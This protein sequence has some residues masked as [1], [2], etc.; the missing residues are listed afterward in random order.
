MEGDLPG[1]RGLSSAPESRRGFAGLP[2][3]GPTAYILIIIFAA[4]ATYLYQ[5][6]YDG[7]FA[8]QA[9]GYT[10]DAFLA[11]CSAHQYGN[12]EHGAF[13]FGLEPRALAAA[14]RARV[15]FLGDSRLQ[16][17]FSTPETKDWFSRSGNSYYLLGFGAGENMNFTGKLLEKIKPRAT[18]YIINAD[19]FFETWLTIP[20][21]PIFA[22]PS[23]GE[24]YKNKS[25][26]QIP[27]KYFCAFASPLCGDNFAAFRSEA[28]GTYQL[29]GAYDADGRRIKGATVSYSRDINH[30]NVQKYLPRA[31]QLFSQL[32][33]RRDCV[34][35]TIIPYA[36]TRIE[37][38]RTLAATLGV[39]FVAP[40]LDGL[41][42]FDPTH[43]DA[44]SAQLWAQKFYEA[45][46][47]QLERCASGKQTS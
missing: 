7:I 22:D 3:I 18:A 30:Q 6:R 21:K 29:A 11:E 42:M 9:R 40:E 4:V 31:E 25:Y 23:T 26:W 17:A 46:G 27:H 2:A 36:G 12:Y 16:V 5:L 35:L 41:K 44:A 10:G 19:N 28:T 45:A 20:V 13:W 24:R 15:L 39:S 47:P 43:L 8:C 33:V 37:T 34:I 32:G 14:A 1:A 38:A